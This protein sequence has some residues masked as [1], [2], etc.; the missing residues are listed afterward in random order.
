MSLP[1]IRHTK[2]DASE[3]KQETW[4]SPRLP[5]IDQPHRPTSPKPTPIFGKRK[6]YE[7]VPKKSPKN[8]E[9]ELF[10][11]LDAIRGRLPSQVLANNKHHSQKKSSDATDPFGVKGSV[12]DVLKSVRELKIEEIRLGGK[13]TKKLRKNHKKTRKAKSHK[14]RRYSAKK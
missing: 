8:S 3:T 14:N 9:P 6:H 4:A 1:S 11:N 5:T 13:R 7:D 12:A 10:I 2:K